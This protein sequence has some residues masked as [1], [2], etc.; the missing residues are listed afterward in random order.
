MEIT[1]SNNTANTSNTYFIVQV[2][3]DEMFWLN[4]ATILATNSGTLT[5]SAKWNYTVGGDRYWRIFGTN[6]N[7]TATPTLT[8]YDW[9]SIG[10]K[11]GIQGGS[12]TRRPERHPHNLVNVWS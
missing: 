6:W 8:N 10:S 3:D 2:S 11:P 5:T 12:I 9:V 7:D 1:T 4:Y